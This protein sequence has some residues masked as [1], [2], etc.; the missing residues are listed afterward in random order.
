MLSG[1]CASVRPEAPGSAS[2]RYTGRGRSQG[3]EHEMPSHEIR[4]E[5]QSMESDAGRGRGIFGKP[6]DSLWRHGPLGMAKRVNRAM[7]SLFRPVP[8]SQ[9]LFSSIDA[10]L[11]NIH[12]YFDGAIDRKFGTDTS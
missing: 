8:G 3:R 1:R 4:A 11:Y 7:G 6:L 2:S 5:S 9:Y 12:N 10:C